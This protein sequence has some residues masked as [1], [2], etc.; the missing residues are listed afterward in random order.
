MVLD[1]MDPLC[2]CRHRR[3]RHQAEAAVMPC[4]DCPCRLFSSADEY[5]EVLIGVAQQ[6]GRLMR[7]EPARARERVAGMDRAD[8]EALCCVLAAVYDPV[9]PVVPWWQQV[10]DVVAARRQVLTEALAPRRGAA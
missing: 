10:P 7:S 9:P 2:R 8:L 6:L 3:Q 5:A 1:E 4:L